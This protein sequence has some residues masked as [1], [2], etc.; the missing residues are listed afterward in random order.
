MA[1]DGDA[2]RDVVS[3]IGKGFAVYQQLRPVCRT[4]TISLKIK[5]RI[6]NS[7]IIPTATYECE[8]WKMTASIKRRLNVFHQRFLRRI[9]RISYHNHITNDEVYCRASSWPLA[10]IVTERPFQFAG[11]ILRKPTTCLT[12]TAMM[13]RPRQAKRK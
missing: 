4:N 6:Y 13:W 12:R 8:T 1:S 5:L 3:R 10:D 2:E 11:H 9:L 7:I